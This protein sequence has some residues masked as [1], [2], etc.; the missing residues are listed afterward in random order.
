MDAGRDI[1]R[2]DRTPEPAAF[3][4]V[5]WADQALATYD[6]SSL[7]LPSAHPSALPLTPSPENGSP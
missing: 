4:D 3:V 6:A 5:G 1:D 7:V 2:L